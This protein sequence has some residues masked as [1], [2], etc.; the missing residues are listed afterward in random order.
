MG[1]TDKTMVFRI[2][3]DLKTAFERVAKD[4]DLTASQMLRSFIREAVEAHAS[5]N[6]QKDLFR[7]SEEIKAPKAS[8]KTKKPP[9][10]SKQALLDMFKRK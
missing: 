1:N 8:Q 7:P 6:S 10:G 2:E 5:K 4:L 3:N 9:T